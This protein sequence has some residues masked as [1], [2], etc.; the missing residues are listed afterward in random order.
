[1][2]D[3]TAS[4]AASMGEPFLLFFSSEQMKAELT[5]AGFTEVE[6]LTG[7]DI[8]SRYY[9]QRT[10]G[11]ALRGAMAQIASAWIRR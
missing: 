2:L 5:R 6:S 7:P 9:A 8:Q 10:D 11:L 3:A 4:M 1:M